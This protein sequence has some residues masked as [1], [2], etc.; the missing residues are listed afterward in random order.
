MLKQ[1]VLL[2]RRRRPPPTISLAQANLQR[3]GRISSIGRINSPWRRKQTTS[4]RWNRG[5]RE[6]WTP[7]RQD[8]NPRGAASRQKPRS[9]PSP[10][11]QGP[12][13]RYRNVR[14]PG[15]GRRCSEPGRRWGKVDQCVYLEFCP[16]FSQAQSFLA[17]E[18]KLG[19]GSVYQ[20]TKMEGHILV[21]LS[22]GQLAD[23]LI[24]EGLDIED[25]TLRAFPIWKRAERIVLGNIFFF[26]EDTDLVSALRPYGQVTS[27]S[28]KL[29]QLDDSCWA[30]ARREVF[31]TLRDAVKLSQIPARLDVKSKVVVTHVYVTYGIKCSLCFK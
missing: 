1:S 8:G 15:K 14:R 9:Q 6:Q 31:I 3:A 24:E 18:A 13:P 19:K 25:A 2:R 7:K 5:E 4:P 21:G 11:A 23:K 10:N 17:L 26:V 27:I 29:M 22:S 20:L 30:D 12:G 16:D 28:K